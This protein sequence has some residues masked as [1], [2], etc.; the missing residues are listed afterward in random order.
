MMKTVSGEI[1][2]ANEDFRGQYSAELTIHRPLKIFKNGGHWRPIVI[3]RFRAIGDGGTSLGAEI[4]VMRAFVGVLKS[5]PTAHV[6]HKDSAIHGVTALYVNEQFAK[7]FT[8]S[9]VQTALAFVGIDFYDNHA[10]CFGILIDCEG[11]ILRGVPLM[12]G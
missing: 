4:F 3:E 2:L 7:L 8:P 6:I 10:V 1:A 11:L 5:T 9:N 12:V